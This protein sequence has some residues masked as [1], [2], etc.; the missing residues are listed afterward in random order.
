MINLI[1]RLFTK[2]KVEVP[3]TIHEQVEENIK[4]RER[5]KEELKKKSKITLWTSED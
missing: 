3:K 2:K 5:I 4:E 1:K